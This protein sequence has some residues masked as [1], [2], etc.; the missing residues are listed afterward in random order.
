VETGGDWDMPRFRCG[1]EPLRWKRE[2]HRLVRNGRL[3]GFETSRAYRIDSGKTRVWCFRVEKDSNSGVMHTTNAHHLS[4]AQCSV[5]LPKTV[6]VVGLDR[7]VGLRLP[8]GDAPRP[9][10]SGLDPA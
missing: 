9:E 8:V 1:I 7:R 6:G 5:R 10:L 2:R 3:Q 4:A